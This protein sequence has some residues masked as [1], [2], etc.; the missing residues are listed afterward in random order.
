MPDPNS[1][2]AAPSAGLVLAGDRPASVVAFDTAMV[3]FC[4]DA[5]TL[6]GVPKSVAAIYAIVFASP[7]PLSFAEIESRL[8]ISKGSV[9]QGL[10]VLREVAAVKEVSSDADRAERFEPELELRKLAGRFLDHRLQ[11]QLDAGEKRLTQLGRTLPTSRKEDMEIL[12]KRLKSLKTWHSR[13][14]ALLPLAKTF[15]KLAPS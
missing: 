13:T 12:R 1:I 15:L 7:Q 5:A 11:R 8:N 3:D 9:S 14:R 4:V 6:L 2:P 10:R